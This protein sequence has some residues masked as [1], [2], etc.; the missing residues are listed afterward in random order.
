MTDIT[1]VII[2]KRLDYYT[3]VKTEKSRLI[4]FCAARQP[5]RTD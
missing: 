2:G 4:H 5:R 1:I 3:N